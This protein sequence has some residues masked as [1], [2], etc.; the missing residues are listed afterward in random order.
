MGRCKVIEMGVNL[1]I[2]YINMITPQG[3]LVR[4]ILTGICRRK[5]KAIPS[6]ISG[7]AL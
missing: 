6:M 3:H 7:V 2:I 4:G 1:L 5:Y